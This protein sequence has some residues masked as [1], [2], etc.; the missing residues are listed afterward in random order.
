MADKKIS[1]L[2]AAT[3][4]LGGT[5]V[6]PIV[7]SGSTVKVPVSDLTAGRSVPMLSATLSGGVVNGVVYLNASKVTTSGAALTFD[8][9][10]LG[11]GIATPAAPLDVTGPSNALQA[12]FG[13]Q[14][15]RGLEIKTFLAVGT[16]NAGV[17]YDAPVVGAGTHVFQ[18]GSVERM[19]IDDDGN[20]RVGTAAIT[21][22]ATDG[23]LYV[24]TCA[25]VPTGTPSAIAGLSPIVIDSTNHRLYFY[26]GGSWR[27]AGP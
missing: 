24:P 27:N 23:Y 25:G 14:A 13:N 2:A 15:G 8:G 20:V 1:Q 12:R 11:I 10:N 4:P 21:T 17:I 18:T 19:R 22:T 9:T 3:T 6:V 7:Q 5:E 16:N 26:S